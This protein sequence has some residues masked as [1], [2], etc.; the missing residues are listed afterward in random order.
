MK[1][2]LKL[3]SLCMALLMV[4][5][6]IPSLAVAE[7]PEKFVW[8][9]VGGA[10][11]HQPRINAALS[12]FLQEN[13]FNV[14]VEVICLGWGD[15]GQIY[16]MTIASGEAFDLFN[17]PGTMAIDFGLNG[18]VIEITDEYLEKYIPTVAAVSGENLLN[19][20]KYDGQLWGMPAVHEWAQYFG[21]S[22]YNKDIADALNLDMSVIH[23]LADLEAY[24]PAIHEA[25]PEISVIDPID[26]NML[27]AAEYGFEG[28]NDSWNTGCA[29]YYDE[30]RGTEVKSVLEIP[31]VTELFKKYREW[32]LKGYFTGIEDPTVNTGT[33]RGDGKIFAQVCRFKPGTDAQQTT[34]Q[35]TLQSLRFDP[36]A[37]AIVTMHDAP[38]GWV[39][40]IP[41]TCKDPVR[42]MKIYEFAY[43]NV[44]F[45]N[46][47]VMGEEGVDYTF[48]ADGFVEFVPGQYAEAAY[49]NRTW[50]TANQN[51]NYVTQN[52]ANLGLAD[53]WKVQEE[54]NATAKTVMPSGF[55]FM[56]SDVDIEVAALA[57]VMSEYLPGLQR[58]QYEDVEATMK[59]F[60]EKM[61]ANGL[62]T[63]LEEAN[64]QYK[65]FLANK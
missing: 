65:E 35:A 62:E 41:V 13:G 2:S 1:K 7:E 10:N 19:A 58:G 59:E 22:Y 40:A 4:A 6:C 11:D 49:A 28:L 60:I 44:D 3:L 38:A 52:Y 14:E 39:T 54:Y 25:Y 43:T 51:L 5:L 55:Y 16:Q 61:Y 26:T 17:C 21:L 32:N 24:F 30:E 33:L 37:P 42:A 9:N 31:E 36:D 47:L 64:R 29:I 53:I 34:P 46:M 12:K 27:C 63:V 18:G 45:I 50:Q 15:Y 23:S 8:Y 57:N 20:I 56:T 48:N